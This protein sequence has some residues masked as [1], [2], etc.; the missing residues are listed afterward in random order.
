METYKEE[1]AKKRNLSSQISD[2]ESKIQFLDFEISTIG[3]SLKKLSDEKSN[4]DISLLGEIYKEA[5]HYLPELN[6]QFDEVVSFHNQMIQNRINFIKKSQTYKQIQLDE[7]SSK[8]EVLLSEKKRITID[9]LDE[10]LLDDLNMFNQKIEELSVQKGE[11]LQSIS[12]LSEQERLKSELNTK[13]Q[14]IDEQT[15]E[16]TIEENLKLFNNFFS[17][18]CEKLYS[19]KYLLA[20]NSNWKEEKKFPITVASFGGNV[21]TGKKKAVIVAFDLAYLKYAE[22]K[23]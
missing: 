14:E 18:Y 19:E 12:L 15:D 23:K 13:I 9:I 22:A 2:L 4:I 8:M 10:G 7:F 5:K 6:R 20:Y 11:I 17:E 16:N 1:L 21:G 3:D